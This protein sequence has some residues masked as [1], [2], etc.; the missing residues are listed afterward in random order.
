MHQET[1]MVRVVGIRQISI[2]HSPKTVAAE[3]L[4]WYTEEAHGLHSYGCRGPVLLIPLSSFVNS[5]VIVSLSM[6]LF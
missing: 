3:N 5:G 6:S 1:A 2:G 4:R